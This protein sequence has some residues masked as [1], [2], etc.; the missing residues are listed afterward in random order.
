M[1]VEEGLIDAAAARLGPRD[2]GFLRRVYAGG[3][4]RYRDRLAAI[5]FNELGRVLDA[6]CGFG[7]WTVAL[8]ESCASVEGID[9]SAARIE[10][11]RIVGGNRPNI[12]FS[13]GRL[14][15]L[16][17]PDVSFDGVFCYSVI[18]YTDVERSVAEIARVLKPGGRVYLCSNGLG[19][20]LHNIVNAP[21]AEKDFNPRAYGLRTLIESVRYRM[22]RI[23]PT[24]QGSI[25][26]GRRWVRGLL[27]RHGL[28]PIADGAEGTLHLE[29]S[30]PKPKSFFAPRYFGMEGAL[31]W[32]A[33]KR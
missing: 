23:P 18:Y 28:T 9:V 6:G 16:P 3:L 32:V 7:Q 11:A 4:Q 2:A 8:A 22:F 25:L 13:I 15:E 17:Y 24:T 26:T 5:G 14:T 30:A 10:A 27:N 19:W 31:E 20:Y 12:A 21:Y 1:A 29:T 33:V